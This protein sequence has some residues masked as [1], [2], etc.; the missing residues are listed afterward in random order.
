[1]APRDLKEFFAPLINEAK[2]DKFIDLEGDDEIEVIADAM[3]GAFQAEV[4]R[5]TQLLE[6][7]QRDILALPAPRV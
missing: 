4:D 7:V 2:G 1:M 6:Q 5:V 3:T